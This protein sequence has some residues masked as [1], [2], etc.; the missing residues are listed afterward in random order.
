MQWKALSHLAQAEQRIG[1]ISSLSKPAK[2]VLTKPPS[3]RLPIKVQRFS[4]EQLS[5]L[6]EHV[7]SSIKDRIEEAKERGLPDGCAKR[8]YDGLWNLKNSFRLELC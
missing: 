1:T 4:V 3:E 7:V 6:E 2:G 5:T 8:L